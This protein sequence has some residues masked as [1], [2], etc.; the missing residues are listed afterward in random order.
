ML[1]YASVSTVTYELSAKLCLTSKCAVP[2]AFGGVVVEVLQ[3]LRQAQHGLK[4]HGQG[5]Q[6]LHKH[7]RVQQQQ[8]DDRTQHGEAE[9]EEQVV[10]EGAPPPEVAE[11]QVWRGERMKQIQKNNLIYSILVSIVYSLEKLN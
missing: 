1:L 8:G 2:H 7:S 9:A 10:L 4:Q 5:A 11:V 3:Q 6:R